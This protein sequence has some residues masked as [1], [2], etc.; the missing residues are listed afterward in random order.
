M[1]DHACAM[2]LAHLQDDAPCASP[3]ALNQ[4]PPA[5]DVP[6]RRM[7]RA[8][9]WRHAPHASTL[10]CALPSCVLNARPSPRSQCAALRMH[11]THPR[12][13]AHPA[14]RP[15]TR[16]S[17]AL[18]APR[19]ARAMPRARRTMRTCSSLS[20][21]GARC[22]RLRTT[23]PRRAPSSACSATLCRCVS[24]GIASGEAWQGW[25]EKR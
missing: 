4:P 19:S 12:C 5:H 25:V 10:P 14:M 13:D 15:D 17:P 23:A 9:V 24:R 2:R 18:H 7:C 3:C 11:H 21:S 20:S 1:Y 6:R 16:Q 8:E 22:R